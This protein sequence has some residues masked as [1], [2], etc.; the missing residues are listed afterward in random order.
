[1]HNFHPFEVVGPGSKTQLQVGGNL[2]R[3]TLKDAEIFLYKL[4]RL[5]GGFQFEIIINV[6]GIFFRFI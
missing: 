4:W 6:L 3:L 2:N 1:M 5:K